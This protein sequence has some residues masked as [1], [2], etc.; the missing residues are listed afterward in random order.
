MARD[1]RWALAYIDAHPGFFLV[2]TLRRILYLW[3]GF[4]SFSR[5]YLAQEPLDVPNIFFSASFTVL[6]LLGLWRAFRT[7]AMMAAPYAAMLLSFP[8]VY[9]VTHVEV[10]YRRQIDPMMVVLAVYAITTMA[11][12][13][14][15]VQQPEEE[16]QV[17]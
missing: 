11:R 8:V 17:A 7:N 6:C 3:T 5:S 1:Q 10:Y 12:K 4:W 15:E 16:L 13:K 9:Y 2:T 14:T